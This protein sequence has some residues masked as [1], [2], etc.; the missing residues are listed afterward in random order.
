[1][2]ILNPFSNMTYGKVKKGSKCLPIPTAEIR[3]IQN[4]CKKKDDDIRWLIA[5]LSDTCIR[6]AEACGL[7]V[8]DLRVDADI[9]RVLIRPHPWQLLKTEASQ[10]AIPLVGAFLL[11]A[12]R[13][14]E[15]KTSDLAFPRYCCSIH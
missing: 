11:A 5:I 15:N 3:L 13:L 2:E 7:L 6:L 8:E 1:M 12:K 10:R 9:P 14:I 4:E